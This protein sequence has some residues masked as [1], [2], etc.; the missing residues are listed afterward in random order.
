[1]R[2]YEISGSQPQLVAKKAYQICNTIEKNCQPF[3]SSKPRGRFLYRGLGSSTDLKKTFIQA[4]YPTNRMPKDSHACI[5]N[6]IIKAFHDLGF[7]ANRDNSVFCY[8]G[9]NTL[10]SSTAI[11]RYGDAL[12]RYLVFPIGEFSIT[13]SS[14]VS[15]LVEVSEI[16]QLWMDEFSNLTGL[17]V[18]NVY[19]TFSEVDLFDTV[20][21]NIY[22]EVKSIIKSLNYSSDVQGA[23]NSTS[24]IM[25]TGSEYYMLAL[26]RF[27]D[28]P[29]WLDNYGT[30]EPIITVRPQ[31]RNIS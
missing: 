5:H 9:S 21:N 28:E 10:C 15:D 12:N 13:Y 14:L 3:L 29:S 2:L 24:E 30:D 16:E 8:S 17:P 25:V 6:L 23:M 19:D 4:K 7:A 22:P 20:K 1:M 27:N 31:Y 18:K 11:Y 26:A